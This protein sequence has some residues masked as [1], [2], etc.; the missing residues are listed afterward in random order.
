MNA[1]APSKDSILSEVADFED[2]VIS[3][4]HDLSGARE[5]RYADDCKHSLLLATDG[6]FAEIERLRAQ[7]AQYEWVFADGDKCAGIVAD[8]YKGWDPEKP[9]R[10]AL[11]AELSY[12]DRSDIRGAA[13]AAAGC[14]YGCIEQG[15]NERECPMHGQPGYGHETIRNA[16]VPLEAKHKCECG[17][18]F[19]TVE[20]FDHHQECCADHN[21]TG[22]SNAP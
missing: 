15:E 20:V 2:A 17:K 21:R 13:E 4:S 18:A 11:T 1:S 3:A 16:A 5:R 9:W 19:L 12:R 8:A 22:L 10:D 6:L 14:T 7:L